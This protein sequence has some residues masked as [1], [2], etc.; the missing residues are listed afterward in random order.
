MHLMVNEDA[1]LEFRDGRGEGRKISVIES[2]GTPYRSQQYKSVRRAIT[3][4]TGITYHIPDY[5]D[6]TAVVQNGCEN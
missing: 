5:A 6:M 3:K 2:N 4:C 1:V